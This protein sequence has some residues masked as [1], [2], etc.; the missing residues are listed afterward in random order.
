MTAE[1][2][3]INIGSSGA[4]TGGMFSGEKILVVAGKVEA[5][6]PADMLG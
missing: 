5:M 2:P 6:H 1:L 3:I 4:E